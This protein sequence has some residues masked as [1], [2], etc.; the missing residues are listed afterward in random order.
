M[1]YP[2]NI[3]PKVPVTVITD[4]I[5][6]ACPTTGIGDCVEKTT[7]K[8]GMFVLRIARRTR[9]ANGQTDVLEMGA[10]FICEIS[11]FS[12]APMLEINGILCFVHHRKI[13]ILD[14]TVSIASII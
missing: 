6:F 2:A 5:F 7:G 3:N 8:S 11:V 1:V 4:P 10:I 14:C 9:P 12:A 13:A